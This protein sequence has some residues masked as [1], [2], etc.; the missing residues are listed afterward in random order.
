MTVSNEVIIDLLPLY[1]AGEASAA[2][3]ELV[4]ER[5]QA[6]PQLAKLAAAIRS[7]LT[8]P[9]D[10][11]TPKADLARTTLERTRKLIRRRT[12]TVALALLFTFLPLTFAFSG[13]KVTFLMVRDA[14]GSALLWISAAY[15]WVQYFRLERKLSVSNL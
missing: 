15:L 11:L 1:V 12:W 4:E 5:V 6:D 2:T 3:A 7:Q 8:A 13:D 9:P 10:I 14:P